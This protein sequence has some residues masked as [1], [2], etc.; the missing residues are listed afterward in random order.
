MP[1]QR[2]ECDA[3]TVFKKNIVRA[4][5]FLRLFDQTGGPGQPS[6]DRKELLRGAVVFSI[7][8]LDAFLND[9]VLELVPRFGPVSEELSEGLKS[10]AKEDPALA[11][12]V[13]LASDEESRRQQFSEALE[14]WLVTKTFHGPQAV[15][16]ATGYVGCS[17]TWATLNELAGVDVPKELQK[18]TDMR[19]EIVH[20]GARP[21]VRRH[22]AE[23]C[24]DLV[25]TIA[26]TVNS[27]AVQYYST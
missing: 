9:L 8:A 1:G 10:I 5:A 12:R 26:K 25:G 17:V 3:Y 19:H 24:V 18:F 13:A 27:E 15:V 14:R 6:N 2:R 20:R 23:S 21:Y 22:H 11:L 7:G 4:R 16:K